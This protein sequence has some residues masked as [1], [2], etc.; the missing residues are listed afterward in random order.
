MQPLEGQQQ[1]SAEGVVETV[2][3]TQEGICDDKA[4]ALNKEEIW[5]TMLVTRV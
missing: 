4:A 1:G 5:D 2:G 3:V